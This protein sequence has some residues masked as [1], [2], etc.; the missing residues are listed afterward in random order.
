MEALCRRQS[1]ALLLLSGEGGRGDADEK[2]KGRLT[3]AALSQG[4]TSSSPSTLAL[5]EALCLAR[6]LP[7]R[8]PPP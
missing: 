5:G 7:P 3:R 1:S 8:L 6:R 4:E 2:P